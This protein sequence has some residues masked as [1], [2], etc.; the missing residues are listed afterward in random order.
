MRNAFANNMSSDTKLSKVQLSKVT[1]S[2]EFLGALLGKLA[3]PLIKI[4]VSLAKNVLAPL[5]T[6]TSASLKQM[7]L[8][9]KR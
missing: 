6:K 4:D 2:R 3:G 8:F 7:V 5:A 1:K 9:N